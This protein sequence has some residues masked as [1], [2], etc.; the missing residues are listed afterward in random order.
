MNLNKNTT[1]QY[2]FEN[3]TVYIIYWATKETPAYTFLSYLKPKY[4][5]T[6]FWLNMNTAMCNHRIVVIIF[7]FAIPLALTITSKVCT[8][9]FKSHRA[10]EDFS[11]K[12][13]DDHSQEA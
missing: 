1:R 11:Q 13:L 7:G 8:P 5:K 9:E 10:C 4:Q 2:R 12:S 3:D 6:I